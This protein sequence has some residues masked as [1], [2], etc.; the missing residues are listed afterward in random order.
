MAG[1]LSAVEGRELCAMLLSGGSRSLTGSGD[2][3]HW[4][5]GISSSSA[6]D[7]EDDDSDARRSLSSASRPSSLLA[8]SPIRIS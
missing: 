5:A 8:G 6:E 3:G 1:G 4:D 7:S 2:S